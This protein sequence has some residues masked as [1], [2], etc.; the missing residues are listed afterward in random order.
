MQI[1]YRA[2]S[3]SSTSHAFAGKFNTKRQIKCQNN[4]SKIEDTEK[5]Q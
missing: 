2:A 4:R 3:S 5:L 1:D